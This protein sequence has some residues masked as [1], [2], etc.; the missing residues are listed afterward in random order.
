MWKGSARTRT[1]TLDTQMPS[2]AHIQEGCGHGS[3]AAE[4]CPLLAPVGK[5]GT[6]LKKRKGNTIKIGVGGEDS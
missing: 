6:H 4:L 5:T 2:T 3:E 1:Q